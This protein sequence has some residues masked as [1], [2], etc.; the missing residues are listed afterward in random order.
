MSARCLFVLLNSMVILVDSLI[1][2]A[3]GLSGLTS[4][5]PEYIQKYPDFFTLFQLTMRYVSSD[6][7][8]S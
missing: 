4:T 7:T 3:K 6:P 1:I 2:F 5:V 8:L